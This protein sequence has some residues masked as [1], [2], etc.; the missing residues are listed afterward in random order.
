VLNSCQHG[1]ELVGS[2]KHGEFLTSWLTVS[3]SR[4]TLF[5]AIN[6]VWLAR[7]KLSFRCLRFLS[8]LDYVVLNEIRLNIVAWE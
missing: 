8:Y 2:I 5:H 7:E 4:R 6:A 3:F 1:N